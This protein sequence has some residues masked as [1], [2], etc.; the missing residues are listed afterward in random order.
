[1]TVIING[2]AGIT[3]P[4]GQIQDVG[5][6]DPGTS[7][8]VLTS[9]GTVWTS[10][11]PSPNNALSQSFTLKSGTTL[12]AGRAVNINSSGQVGDYPVVNAISSTVTA[13]NSYRESLI[14]TISTNGSR[15]IDFN[16]PSNNN[17]A[18]QIRGTAITNTTTVTGSFVTLVTGWYTGFNS[19]PINE[20]QFLIV[21]S[22]NSAQESGTT[23]F[24]ARVVTVD[25]SGAITLGTVITWTVSNI[26]GPFGS[27]IQVSPLPFGRFACIAVVYNSAAIEQSAGRTFSISGTTVTATSDADLNWYSILQS[28]TTSNNRLVGYWDNTVQHCTYDGSVTSSYASTSVNTSIKASTGNYG[29][30]LNAS[31]GISLYQNTAN[32]VLLRTYSINQTTGVPTVTSDYVLINSP[33]NLTSP[34]IKIINSTDIGLTYRLGTSTY[35]V[36]IKLNATG[37][38]VGNGIPLIIDSA[39][40]LYFGLTTTDTSGVLRSIGNASSLGVSKQITINTFDT[41]SWVS[42]GA[43]ATSQSTSPATV[44]VGGICGGFSGLTPGI[45]YYVNEVTYDGQITTTVGSYLVGTAVSTTQIL[46]G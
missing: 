43:T 42:V 17:E 46:L 28:Y 33:L 29:G 12:T 6:P 23:T 9:N 8:N 38:V 30:L 14:S 21:Y 11:T 16:T 3:F 27:V 18:I 19:Y 22:T 35:F 31:Y 13:G 40:S 41:L 24:Y 20:T 37:Q 26:Y 32:D 5:V 7:G 39:G 10:A 4:D 44:T 25:A 15:L 34:R 1:M 45:K 36:S 2:T